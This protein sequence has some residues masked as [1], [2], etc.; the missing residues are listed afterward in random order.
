MRTRCLL[1]LGQSLFFALCISACGTPGYGPE[2]SYVTIRRLSAVSENTF[3]VIFGPRESRQI[4]LAA[5]QIPLTAPREQHQEAWNSAA[6]RVA[7]EELKVRELCM[8]RVELTRRWLG[9]DKS[10]D[11]EII[12]RCIQ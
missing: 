12:V 11:S 9:L 5:S 8:S 7:T 6:L 4:G 10:M 2:T 3:Q 1:S